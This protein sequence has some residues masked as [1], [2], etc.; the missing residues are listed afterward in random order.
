MADLQAA[1]VHDDALDDEL[2][3]GL[4]VGKARLIEP[5]ADAIAEGGQIM[6]HRLSFELLAASPLAIG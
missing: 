4:L 3:D 6:E 5:A 2:Q 1:I